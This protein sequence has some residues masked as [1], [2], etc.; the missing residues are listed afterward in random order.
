MKKY[1]LSVSILPIA[2]IISVF[3]NINI[4]YSQ[5]HTRE[6]GDFSIPLDGFEDITSHNGNLIVVGGHYY[7]SQLWQ[8]DPNDPGGN[9]DV[10]NLPYDLEEVKAVASLDGDLYVANY[11]SS[12][13]C[14][15]D[16]IIDQ[17]WKI[18]LDDPENSTRVGTLP[19]SLTT[20]TSMTSHNG[21]LYIVDSA[22]DLWEIDPNNKG[23]GAIVGDLPGH[24]LRPDAIFSH[25]GLLYIEDV[26]DEEIWQINMDRPEESILVGSLPESL[27][28]FAVMESHNGILYLATR[29]DLWQ[30]DLSDLEYKSTLIEGDNIGILPVSLPRPDFLAPWDPNILPRPISM[31][32]LEGVLYMI[33]VDGKEN[34]LW[35]I[36]LN[37]PE[38]NSTFEILP[39]KLQRPSAMTLHEGSLY[40]VDS[41]KDNLLKIDPNNLE[42]GIVF[43]RDLPSSWASAITS[44]NGS[45]YI[46]DDGSDTGK[47][48]WK[49]DINDSK[50]DITIEGRWPRKL[51]WPSGMVSIGGDLYISDSFDNELWKID[52]TNIANIDFSGDL[53]A[54]PNIMTSLDGVLYLAD[55]YGNNHE[56]WQINL[57]NSDYKLRWCKSGW[58]TIY[59]CGV[60]GEEFDLQGPKEIQDNEVQEEKP[61]PDFTS[62]SEIVDGDIIQADGDIDVYVVKIVGEKRFKRLILSASVFESYRHLEWKNIKTVSRS[63]L[64]LYVT[65]NLVQEVKRDGS[66]DERVFYL[67]ISG[68]DTG[69]KRHLQITPEQFIEVGLDSDSI[70]YINDTE[71]S[72]Y[73][74]GKPIG[75]DELEEALGNN[76]KK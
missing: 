61:E 27:P 41:G 71:A 58:G 56:L 17:L 40:L 8:I 50:N 57:S 10:V 69:I 30:T 54:R 12:V 29:T 72:I 55:T 21:L 45:L 11:L 53:P 7:N 36:D 34:Q 32:E 31:A 43:V 63:I 16:C 65:S 59:P 73:S 68:E 6:I 70:Y 23:D 74:E 44:H 24:L 62:T 18:D 19:I 14:D 37:D 60:G 67:I 1:I 75:I 47:K 38:N 4:T 42:D 51:L 66:V 76:D 48:L 15:Y 26:D 28:K 52:L 5:E 25:N 46:L 33:M 3:L 20:P 49:I 13:L 64:D 39:A 9:I 2:L 35:Q 22:G